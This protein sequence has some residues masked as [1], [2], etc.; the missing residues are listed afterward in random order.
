MDS[1]TLQNHKASWE[2]FFFFNFIYDPQNSV[3]ISKEEKD[4]NNSI[5]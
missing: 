1:A 5:V 3:G 2:T 4:K